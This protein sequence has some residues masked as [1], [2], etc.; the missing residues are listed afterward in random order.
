MKSFPGVVALLALAFAFYMFHLIGL[1]T[2]DFA[3]RL[4]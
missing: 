2:S 4:P 1:V 3:A